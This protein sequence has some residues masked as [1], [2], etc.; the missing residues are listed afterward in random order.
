MQK[1]KQDADEGADWQMSGNGV[2]GKGTA[3]PEE[4]VYG[5]EGGRSH[6]RGSAC[7]RHG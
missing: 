6:L 7:T 5:H 4:E 3:W 1:Q 2:P